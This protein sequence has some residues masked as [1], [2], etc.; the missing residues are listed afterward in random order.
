MLE[1]GPRYDYVLDKE[2]DEGFATELLEVLEKIAKIT[3][4]ADIK[5]VAEPCVTGEC[6]S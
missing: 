4:D 2:M 5:R 1:Q 3:P 6:A